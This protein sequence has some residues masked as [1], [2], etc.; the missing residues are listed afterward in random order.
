VIRK[1]F[2]VLA[3]ALLCA[4]AQARDAVTI[5]FAE[6]KV[7]DRVKVVEEEEGVS[8]TTARMGD[9]E[10][11]REEKGGKKVTFVEEVVT[12]GAGPGNRP[13]KLTRTYERAEFTKGDKTTAGAPLK[14][15]I[16]IEKK[17]GK[18]SFTAGGKAVTGPLGDDL[19]KAFNRPEVPPTAM[20]PD[21]PVMAGES[22]KVNLAVAVPDAPGGMRF[23]R[24]KGTGGGKLVRTVERD[25]ALHGAF[26]LEIE[27]PI[28]ELGGKAQF[29]LKPSSSVRNTVLAFGCIDGTNSTGKTVSKSVVTIRGSAGGATILVTAETNATKTVTPLPKK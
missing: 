22:W 14:T 12:A 4:V 11:V 29:E 25:G 26:E 8:T 23:D 9:E 24:E 19:S 21:K 16:V 18:W 10:E 7:G 15:E 17:D 13:T 5:K 28:T 3:L 2:G 1:T 20:F 6:P 27:L